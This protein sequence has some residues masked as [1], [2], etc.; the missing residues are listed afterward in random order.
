MYFNDRIYS[1]PEYERL[2]GGHVNDVKGIWLFHSFLS[3]AEN[4]CVIKDLMHTAANILKDGM[5]VLAYNKNHRCMSSSCKNGSIA[6][7]M[8]RSI[9]I[10]LV[11]V[12]Q[13][14]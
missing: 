14:Q 8:H 11:S 6:H 1:E 13:K 3:Y 10:L 9:Y 12:V 7:A 2:P 5:Q 4:I